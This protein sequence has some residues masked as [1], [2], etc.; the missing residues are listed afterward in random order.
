MLGASE[1]MRRTGSGMRTLRPVSSCTVRNDAVFAGAAAVCSACD[2]ATHG[3]TKRNAANAALR[4]NEIGT[5]IFTMPRLLLIE[6]CFLFA[7]VPRHYEN[8]NAPR[9][10]WGNK[11]QTSSRE[12]FRKLRHGRVAW[13]TAFQPITVA[14]PR[15]IFTAFPAAL[16][17]KL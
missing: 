14:G 2:C 5:L 4:I 17:C 7:R 3:A 11:A 13:L 10:S 9:V 15:P 1:T 6:A 12:K 16:A 8:K